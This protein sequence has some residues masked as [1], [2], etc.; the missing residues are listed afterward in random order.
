MR[1]CELAGARRDLLDRDA[2]TLA[3]QT[4]QVVVDGRVIES[5]GKTE[6]AQHVLALDP[7]TLAALKMHIDK[8]NQERRELGPDSP[9]ALETLTRQAAV[10]LRAARDQ[11]DS[12]DPASVR[13]QIADAEADPAPRQNGSAPTPPAN[14]TPSSSTTKPNSPQPERSPA[15]NAP[16]PNASSTPNAPTATPSPANSP[17]PPAATA[18]HNRSASYEPAVRPDQ[19]RTITP[20]PSHHSPGR[21]N[22]GGAQMRLTRPGRQEHGYPCYFWEKHPEIAGGL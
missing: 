1:R 2:G 20:S 4:T 8:L 14:A 19:S 17:P 13:A 22:E 11:A 7:V 16:A 10:L 12:P 21:A 3:I 9:A 18:R 15:Q 5:D 6:N